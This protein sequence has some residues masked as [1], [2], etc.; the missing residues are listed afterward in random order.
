ML[1]QCEILVKIIRVMPYPHQIERID[2][3]ENDYVRFTWRNR[4]FRVSGTLSVN[5]A[6]SGILESKDI[7]IILGQLLQYT[8]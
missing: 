1:T 3:S 6:E 2:L 5:L 4:T 8:M 7:S